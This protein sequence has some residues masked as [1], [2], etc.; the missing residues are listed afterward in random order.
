[1][2]AYEIILKKRDGKKRKD[3]PLDK[4]PQRISLVNLSYSQSGRFVNSYCRFIWNIMVRTP[5]CPG[6]PFT[7]DGTV[8]GIIRVVYAGRGFTSYHTSS[9]AASA[10]VVWF[11]GPSLVNLS[12]STAAEPIHWFGAKYSIF[13]LNK[14][15]AGIFLGSAY[16]FTHLVIVK[17]GWMCLQIQRFIGD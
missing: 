6:W 7:C 16:N 2:T 9:G 15:W 12:V 13:L 5:V 8:P 4:K 3:C 14:V 17:L 1:M 11:T 10:Q